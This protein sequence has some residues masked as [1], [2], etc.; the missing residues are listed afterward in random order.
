MAWGPPNPH[1]DT[2]SRISG[3]SS[4]RRTFRRG[5]RNR[6]TAGRHHLRRRL[7][8]FLKQCIPHPEPVRVYGHGLPP[9]AFIDQPSRRSRTGCTA[10]TVGVRQDLLY[11]MVGMTTKSGEPLFPE[12]LLVSAGDDPGFSTAKVKGGYITGSVRRRRFHEGW[13]IG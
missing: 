13:G 7:S 11:M 9:T 1:E 12:R 4:L 8:G 6:S 2:P 5:A 10:G 3:I